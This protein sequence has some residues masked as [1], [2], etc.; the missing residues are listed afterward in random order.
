MN[1]FDKLQV[2]D[3]L[4]DN[5]GMTIECIQK[6][7]DSALFKSLKYDTIYRSSAFGINKSVFKFI[8][9]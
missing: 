8:E 7:K 3:K 2:G 4:T 9:E 1:K 6:E 5:E